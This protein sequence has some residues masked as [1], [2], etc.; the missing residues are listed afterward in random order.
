MNADLQLLC[1][2]YSSLLT[3]T[4]FVKIMYLEKVTVMLEYEGPILERKA[5][6][7]IVEVEVNFN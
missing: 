4:F 6:G 5:K 1:S 7:N 3:F 2:T